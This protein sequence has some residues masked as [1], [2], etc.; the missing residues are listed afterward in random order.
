M[1]LGFTITIAVLLSLF[2]GVIFFRP[3]IP[4]KSL[5]TTIPQ[6]SAVWGRYVPESA[7][8]FGFENYTAIRQYNSSYPTQYKTLLNIIDLKLTLKPAAINSVMTVSFASPNESIAFAFVNQAAFSNFTNA[9]ASVNNTATQVGGDS[10]Y[11]VRDSENGQILFGWLAVIPADRG[12]AFAEGNTAAKAAI[13]ECLLVNPSNSLIS[14]LDVRQ[15]LYV[16]NGTRHLA[17]GIQLFPGVLPQANETM[18]VVDD[19]GSQVVISRVLE[20]GSSSVAQ[21]QYSSVKQ[22]YLK[23]HLITVYDSYVLATEFE[24]VSDLSG[25]VRLVE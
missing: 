18:T 15:M 19:S 1:V 2:F 13:M 7:Q 25:A 6:Y 16:A 21:D 10:M 22:S 20:F 9:F 8:L 4:V 23:A 14:R 11:Y 12:I 3:G 5:P 24:A 17:L